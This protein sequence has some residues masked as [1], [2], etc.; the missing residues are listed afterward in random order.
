M[1]S[2]IARKVI[3]HFQEQE[4]AAAEVENHSTREREVLVLVVC[5]LSN[6]KIVDRLGITIEGAAGI[7]PCQ[8]E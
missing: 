1:N 6:K 7:W 5:G 2:E 3:G 8:V 4:S